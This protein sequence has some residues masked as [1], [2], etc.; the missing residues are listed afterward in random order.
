[1][2]RW[3]WLLSG[4]LSGCYLSPDTHAVHDESNDPV[5]VP[6]AGSGTLDGGLPLPVDAGGCTDNETC[7]PDASV[8]R[9]RTCTACTQHADCSRF[10]TTPA[11]SR[12][13]CVQCTEDNKSLCTGSTPACDPA[14]GACVQ[15]AS[16]KDCAFPER[17]ACGP[18]RTCGVCKE[19][20]DCTRFGRV[21]EIGS[22]MCVEC[23]P[24]TE[25]TDCRTDKA[26]DPSTTDC[27]GT[28]C[29]PET[30]LCTRT[31]RGTLGIC[32]ACVADSECQRD[33]RCIPLYFGKDAGRQELGG[34][35]MK[36]GATT[37][38]EQYRA[39]PIE[40]RISLSGHAPEPYCGINE[41]LTTCPA[42]L[43]LEQDRSCSDGRPQTCSA[44]GAR[45]AAVNFGANH[46][47]YACVTNREC[48]SSAPCGGPQNA[49]Y[50]GG[51]Q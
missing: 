19:D 8:C 9:D 38:S 13:L 50:C 49:T 6:D 26:C 35:C 36:I 2:R 31:P 29:D 1:M 10:P 34:Y 18:D 4:L 46:C 41:E 11:C 33:H 40:G 5:S 12:G 25:S 16:D 51:R 45:C 14:S 27:P 32:V 42:I 37:C 43:A 20:A 48:P 44:L 23:R 15:C 47:T 39:A 17:A 21:C 22:G 28:A 3:A 24:S 7:G 30:K